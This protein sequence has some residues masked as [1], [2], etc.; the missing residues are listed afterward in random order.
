[1]HEKRYVYKLLAH[2]FEGNRFS[3]KS[4]HIMKNNV[5]MGIRKMWYESMGW[6]QLT[7]DMAASKHS[8]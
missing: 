5:E 6:S 3:G 1:L 7:L 8:N 2:K 4:M